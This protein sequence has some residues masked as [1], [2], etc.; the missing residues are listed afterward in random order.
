MAEP[1]DPATIDE[2]FAPA[3]SGSVFTVEL[4]GESVLLDEKANRLHRLNHTGTLLWLLFNGQSSLDD[5]AAELGEA[6][7][8]PHTEVL[9]DLLEITRNLG[10]EGLLDGVLSSSATEDAGEGT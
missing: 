9:H 6:L 3:R 2:D 4:D 10:D 8:A 7:A 5:L 1:V